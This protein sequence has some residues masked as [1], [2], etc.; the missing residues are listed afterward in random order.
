MNMDKEIR[1]KIL[2]CKA[3]QGKTV[4]DIIATDRFRENLAAYMTAQRTDRKA[5]RDSY[6]AM[7]KLGGAAG[8]KLPAHT[9]DRVINLSVE[10]FAVEYAK[11]ISHKSGRGFA[12]REYIRQLGQQ[13]YHLTMV[14]YVV[15]E[16]PELENEL[17]K[18]SNTN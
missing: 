3:L 4:A 7:H 18:K 2:S 9:V 8:Y 14:Q 1:K 10:D 15:D 13:A 16:F 11:V 17:M 5:I 12:E 6:E